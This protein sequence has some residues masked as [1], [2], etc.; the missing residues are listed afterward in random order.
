M[1]VPAVVTDVKGNREVV[2][3]GLNG[4]VVPFGDRVA[5]SDAINKVFADR[6]KSQIMG[7]EGRRIALEHFDQ[8]SVFEK[9]KEVY[10]SLLRKNGL[11]V[12]KY[13]PTPCM[14][15]G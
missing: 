2:K 13:Q 7:Y 1:C 9:V 15:D 8:T 11:P 6:K 5:L 10:A 14:D 12:P 4:L 3:H